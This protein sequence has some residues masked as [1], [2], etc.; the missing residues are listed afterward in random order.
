MKKTLIALAGISLIISNVL[1][2]EQLE[3]KDLRGYGK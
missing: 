2:A 1:L 3:K